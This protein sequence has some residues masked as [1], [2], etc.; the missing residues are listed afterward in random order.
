MS[1]VSQTGIFLST[2]FYGIMNIPV[3][4][5]D[6]T[7]YRTIPGGYAVAVSTIGENLRRLRIEQ[8]LTQIDLARRAGVAQGDVSKWEKGVTPSGKS[9][10][11][12]AVGLSRPLDDLLA[13]LDAEYDSLSAGRVEHVQ[14]SSRVLELAHRVDG[15]E[16]TLSKAQKAA[17]DL[18]AILLAGTK[19]HAAGRTQSAGGKRDRKAG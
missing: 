10:L 9:L 4:P 13:G 5:N 1:G 11:R 15:Y 3:N 7:V 6:A 8:R 16:G 18:L 2:D 14:A 17:T 19:V 12:L